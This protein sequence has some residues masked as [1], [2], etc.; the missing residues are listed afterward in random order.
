MK[1]CIE[2]EG[3]FE[4]IKSHA[5]YCSQKCLKKFHSKK[6]TE[7]SRN[8]PIYREHKNK[9]ERER[10]RNGGRDKIKHAS[11]ERER[12]R[13][14]VGGLKNSPNGSGSLTKHGYRQI[15][16]IGHANAWRTG[17]MFEHVFVMS[18][19]LGR[20]LS[21]GETVHHK[22]GIRSD[23]RIENLE[24]WSSSHPPGQRVIDKL[25]WCKEFLAQYEDEVIIEEK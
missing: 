2:C 12:Y 11:E 15:T 20:P 18:S 19:H 17:Q 21:K 14:K 4:N 9:L 16:A 24:L 25:N 1:K 3:E 7:K 10:R 8:D 13:K 5:V 22:N 6:N 23:N